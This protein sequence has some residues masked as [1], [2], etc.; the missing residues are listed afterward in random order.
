[1]FF[2]DFYLPSIN[3]SANCSKLQK[4]DLLCD[5]HWQ[6]ISLSSYCLLDLSTPSIKNSQCL[7]TSIN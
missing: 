7:L 4:V 5:E 6:L 2:Y 3:E 1:M